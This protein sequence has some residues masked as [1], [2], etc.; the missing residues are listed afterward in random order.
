LAKS[1]E[2]VRKKSVLEVQKKGRKVPPISGT[3]YLIHSDLMQKK[4]TIS[5]RRQ[6]LEFSQKIINHNKKKA[7]IRKLPQKKK[8]SMKYLD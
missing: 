8:L 7:L 3:S 6:M 2:I 5:L 1:F 4:N